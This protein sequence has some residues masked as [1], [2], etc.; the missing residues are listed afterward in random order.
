MVVSYRK[1]IICCIALIGVFI[2]SSVACADVRPLTDEEMDQIVAANL[3]NEVSGFIPPD[4]IPVDIEKLI[5]QVT[6]TVSTLI[7]DELIEYTG[8]VNIHAIN[9]TVDVQMNLN[10]ILDS[11]TTTI[12]QSNRI[13]PQ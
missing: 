6:S 10:Y 8:L 2:C 3:P 5:E 13:D 4:L 7:Q 11:V 1:R 9:S 12:E